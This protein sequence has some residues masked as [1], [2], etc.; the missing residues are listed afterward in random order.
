MNKVFILSLL[1]TLFSLLTSAMPIDNTRSAAYPQDNKVVADGYYT[2]DN[3]VEKREDS[4]DG[5]QAGQLGGTLL[6]NIS[7]LLP[8]NFLGGQPPDED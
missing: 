7:R 4:E 5:K 8:A 6:P 1:C 3:L 2:S